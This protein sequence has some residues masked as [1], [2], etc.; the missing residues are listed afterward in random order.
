MATEVTMPKL[1]DTM[2]EGKILRWLKQPGDPV[3][4]GEIIA[5]VET[6]KANMELESYDDGVLAEIKVG[7]NESAPVGSVIAVLDAPGAKPGA[8]PAAAKAGAAPPAAKPEPSAAAEAAETGATEGQPA[9]KQST[10]SGT[11][12][13]SAAAKPAVAPARPAASAKPG[14]RP[15]ADERKPLRP[16]VVVRDEDAGTGRVKAS[17]LARKIAEERGIDLS[18][19][20][21]SGPGGRVVE[22]DLEGAEAGNA[23]PAPADRG[24]APRPREA[25]AAARP[26]P[27]APPAGRVE[28]SKIRRTTAKRMAEAKRDIPHFYASTDVAMDEAV[29]LKAQLAGVGGDF[30]G[31]TY[32]H[33][34]VKAVG[35]AL[36]R[37]PEVNASYEGDTIVL[38]AEVNVGVATAVG[39]GLMVPVLHDVDA[40]PLGELVREA[41]GLVERARAGKFGGSDLSGATFT[42]SNLGMLPVT[43]F[44]AVVNPPQAAILAVG[45]VREAPVV[46]EKQIV[47]GHV[48]TVTLSSDHRLI[49]GMLAGR[50]LKELKALLETP[51][52]LL[53]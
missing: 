5:E 45:M 32:T 47:P 37:V 10:T 19:I 6:D 27:A 9:A 48:M 49:D 2:E 13:R 21:G 46:R 17:P 18:T 31:I 7:E 33:L 42:V 52:A 8:K 43:E 53:V 34:V 25:A 30:T 3:K 15:A 12:V 14:L 16:T 35:L 22:R 20:T 24:A 23:A 44:A 41:R 26:V 40:K 29:H 11:G 36:A 1:S 4:I 50:F 39:D 51:V 38:H 28:L